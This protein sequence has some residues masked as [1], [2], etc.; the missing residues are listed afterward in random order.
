M[1][2][3]GGKELDGSGREVHVESDE[4]GED[5]APR[6]V[7]APV[8]LSRLQLRAENVDDTVV[9]LEV[10]EIR[11]LEVNQGC[12]EVRLGWNCSAGGQY[13]LFT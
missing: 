11:S 3:V 2:Q 4:G 13:C 8:Q 12:V 7:V 1:D 6:A 9:A 10:F 5:G